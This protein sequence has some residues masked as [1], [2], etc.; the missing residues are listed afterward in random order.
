MTNR[1]SLLPDRLVRAVL[2]LLISLNISITVVS[3]SVNAQSAVP[4]KIVAQSGDAYIAY[5]AVRLAGD[6]AVAT[7]GSQTDPIAEKIASGMSLRD[8]M[9]QSLIVLD[10]EKDDFSTPRI[11]VAVARGAEEGWCGIAR[12]DALIVRALPLVK[13][14]AYYFATYETNEP[15]AEY[16]SDFGAAT[17][18]EAARW[19]V[20]G[21][22]FADLEKPVC[23]AAAVE[24]K[25]GFALAGFTVEAK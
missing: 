10:Y 24:T 8:A 15:K 11:A 22:V 25:D 20:S 18:E 2:V 1:H 17:A 4:G 12:R 23:S 13:G 14:K 21:G 9:V 6:A 16:V 19:V 5:N 3:G 7:N